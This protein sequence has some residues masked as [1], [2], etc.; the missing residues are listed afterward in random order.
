[1]NNKNNSLN[2]DYSLLQKKLEELKNDLN[3]I[4]EENN[5]YKEKNNT[6]EKEKNEKELEIKEIKTLYENNNNEMNKLKKENESLNLDL[7]NLKIKIEKQN[8]ENEELANAN[9]E[10]NT[11]IKEIK[12]DEELV[13]ERDNYKNLY[14]KLDK[15]HNETISEYK[16]KLNNINDLYLNDKNNQNN[17]N[18]LIN[19]LNNKINK[20]N[21]EKNNL[22]SQL[23]DILTENQEL[24]VEYQ[25]NLS[26]LK[27]HYIFNNELND[28]NIKD[29]EYYGEVVT[30]PRS[31]SDYL[32][33]CTDELIKLNNENYHLKS[34][35]NNLNLK[36]DL[37]NKQS[38]DFMI[39]NEKLKNT[40]ENYLKELD[41]KNMVINRINIE[42]NNIENYVKKINNNS[43]YMLTV[44][45]RLCKI[46]QDS[47]IYNL[48]SEIMN[49]KNLNI[50]QKEKINIQ[51]LNEIKN[52]ENYVKELEEDKHKMN[53]LKKN[54]KYILYKKNINNNDAINNMNN[55]SET[56]DKIHLKRFLS[57]NNFN[58]IGDVHKY[59]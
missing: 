5:T 51:L 4:K 44:L 21:E 41:N 16:S 18:M 56:F 26:K 29:S 30:A 8:K 35:I 2:T 13:K 38:N 27:Q 53:N 12:T 10:L 57:N 19:D 7:N 3:K 47:N 28:Q 40:I 25:N 33:K 37:N 43:Q 36:M 46:F 49:N 9:K 48:L 1:M 50:N 22:L 52:C 59:K 17:N 20:I 14:E 32:N 42:K 55:I 6:L 31:L 24:S 45:L 39:I 23:N 15:K 11:K 58:R 34:K 54:N